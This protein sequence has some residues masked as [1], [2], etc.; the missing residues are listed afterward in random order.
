MNYKLN[1]LTENVHIVRFIKSRIAWIGHMM[2][3]DK[4]TPKRVET[5]RYKNQKKTTEKTDCGH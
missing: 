2:C 3:M 4:R 1:E 5:Y